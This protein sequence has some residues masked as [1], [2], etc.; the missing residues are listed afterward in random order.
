[1]YVVDSGEPSLRVFS[2]KGFDSRAQSPC[3]LKEEKGFDSPS[4]IAT[5]LQAST[6]VLCNALLTQTDQ[7]PASAHYLTTG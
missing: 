6:G 7:Y 2:K 3:I 1:M 4:D 5:L